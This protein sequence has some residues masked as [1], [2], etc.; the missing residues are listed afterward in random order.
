MDTLA[1][2][3]VLFTLADAL[4]LSLSQDREGL[5][6]YGESVVA[7]KRLRWS[8]RFGAVLT[9]LGSCVGVLLAYYLT[10]VDAYGS[11]SPL[12]LLVFLLFWLAPVWFLTSWTARY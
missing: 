12:N 7:A 10:S 5:L 6:P 9:C 2:L 1:A 8:T 3:S 4:T 11:L